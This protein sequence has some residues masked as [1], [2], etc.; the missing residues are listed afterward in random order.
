M[1]YYFSGTGNST[2][3]AQGL[4]RRLGETMTPIAAADPAAQTP[5]AKG[6]GFVF[7]VYAWGVAPIVLQFIADLP[8]SFWEKVTANDIPVWCV[9]TCGDETAMAPEMLAKALAR[10]GVTLRG[11]WSVQMPNNYVL[12]PGFDV[13]PESL[14]N[15]KMAK[16]E[17]RLD[18]IA[19]QIAAGACTVDVVRG[20]WPRLKTGAVYP[21]FK[22]WGIKPAKWHA[23]S[24][25]I[26]CGL[27]AEA[28]PVG[29][30]SMQNG[31]PVWGDRCVSCLACYHVCPVHAVA[32]GSGTSGKGQYRTLLKGLRRTR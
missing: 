7:P 18:A 21:L 17:Q 2:L 28:C 8:S 16:S 10:R 29:N 9:M 14:E 11:V 19:E 27:C 31:H 3:V 5:D 25:C 6:I 30:I 15:E 12:L 32:Y 1:I 13:D 20:S 24:S 4:C 23:T 26:S 22:R